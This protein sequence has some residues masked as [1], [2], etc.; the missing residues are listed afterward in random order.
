MRRLSALVPRPL[1]LR[2][3]TVAAAAPRLAAPLPSGAAPHG[4]A[5]AAST[6]LGRPQWR[7]LAQAATDGAE[8]EP[9]QGTASG[10]GGAESA[11][12]GAE[13]AQG[14][15]DSAQDGAETAQESAGDSG[16]SAS[17]AEVEAEAGAAE[18]GEA[19]KAAEAA[20]AE[21]AQSPEEKLKAELSELQEKVK[22]GKHELLLALADFENNK[23][24]FAKECK[25]RKRRSTADFARKVIDVY[26]EFDTFA[27]PVPAADGAE[28][29]L[30]EPC[31][32]L[33]EGI[34]L[35]GDLY[36]AT[37][38]RF[39]VAPLEVESGQPFVAARHES[40]GSVEDGSIA[41][42]AVA[43]LVQPGWEL[44]PDADAA[45]V[46]L[47]KAQVKVARHGP[48]APPAPP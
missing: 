34:I 17:D 14:G 28:A 3:A 6:L 8:S 33:R 11:Q 26:T 41:A 18:G 9:T 35:T 38:E 10:A 7:G 22:V 44:L 23:K 43:E 24:R 13:S 21:K 2:P 30:S 32:A 45:S 16:A 12:G 19:A 37:L 36:K 40:V 1:R 31:Q 29:E 20:E 4:R 42:N 47:R 39:Q 25:A 15:A 46:V 5:H 48:E 27:A